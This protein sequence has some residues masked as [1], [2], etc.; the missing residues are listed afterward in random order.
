MS[1]FNNPVSLGSAY[2]LDISYAELAGANNGQRPDL[3]G[4][5]KWS[6]RTPDGKVWSSNGSIL[7]T[8]S[9]AQSVIIHQGALPMAIP[10]SGSVAANGVVTITTP[11]P[12]NLFPQSCYLRFPAGA[13]FAGS[14]AGL[15]YTVLSSTT[16]G[17]VYKDQY[18]GG[19]PLTP[20]TPEG[21]VAAGPGAYAQTTGADIVL[22]STVIPANS[23]GAG[24][25]VR[26]MFLG[27]I[28]NSA[29][30]KTVKG[31]V[32]AN[33]IGQMALTT[34]VA[35][36]GYGGWRNRGLTRALRATAGGGISFGQGAGGTSSG[37]ADSIAV[38]ATADQ[39]FTMTGQLAAATDYISLDALT[40]EILPG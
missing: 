15:Y 30:N 11:L 6:F 37:P 2:T 14:V 21:I 4:K 17:V 36:C 9:L 23:M 40:V 13:L 24:G 29:T 7:V 12:Y 33:Q 18:F 16:S 20:V 10:S 28:L 27:N 1:E 5:D 39:V 35:I 34:V 22:S 8:A 32:G 26:V 38:D 31:F 25:A 19:V 3:L